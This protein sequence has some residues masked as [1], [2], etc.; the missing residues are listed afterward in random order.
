MQL[1]TEQRTM[2]QF[3]SQKSLKKH[4]RQIIDLIG[5]CSSVKCKYPDFFFDFVR[6]S[7]DTQTI[8]RSFWGSKTLK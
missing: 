4:F 7:R 3:K 1:F 2:T 5:V 6:F 8:Q